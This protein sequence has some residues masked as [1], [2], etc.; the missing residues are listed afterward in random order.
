MEVTYSSSFAAPHNLLILTDNL[1]FIQNSFDS[2]AYEPYIN[3]YL[4]QKKDVVLSFPMEDTM[5]FVALA[6]EEKENTSKKMEGFRRLASESLKL[7]NKEKI[8]QL[9]FTSDMEGNHVI[10][11]TEGMY[12]ADYSFEKYKTD[13]N[14]CLTNSTHLD[15][16]PRTS[17]TGGDVQ[18]GPYE[19]V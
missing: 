1:G 19:D 7:V 18:P 2:L 4:E 6:L 5:V 9:N 15:N 3:K 12:L 16:V 8:T 17:A 10:A 14:E 13:K 11:F